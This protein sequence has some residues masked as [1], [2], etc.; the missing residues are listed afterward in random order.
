M[1]RE[2]NI[3]RYIAATTT[4]RTFNHVTC[5]EI[6][7]RENLTLFKSRAVATYKGKILNFY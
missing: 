7:N 5:E 3:K 6:E 1:F 4:R 2:V